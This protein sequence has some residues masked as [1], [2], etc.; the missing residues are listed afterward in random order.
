MLYNKPMTRDLGFI[1]LYASQDRGSYPDGGIIGM[2]AYGYVQL[3]FSGVVI[4]WWVFPLGVMFYNPPFHI[5]TEAGNASLHG[6][7]SDF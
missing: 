3:M 1:S 4:C 6:H 7:H 2:F 5:V